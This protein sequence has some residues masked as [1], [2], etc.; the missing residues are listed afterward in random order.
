MGSGVIPTGSYFGE[1][2]RWGS[3]LFL[4]LIWPPE[5]QQISRIPPNL[6]S[7]LKWLQVA[8]VLAASKGLCLWTDIVW[9]DLHYGGAQKA[10]PSCAYNTP[11]I[12]RYLPDLDSDFFFYLFLGFESYLEII[13]RPVASFSQ[14]MSP[15]RMAAQSRPKITSP[16]HVFW[17]TP[18]LKPS[19]LIGTLIGV[20]LIC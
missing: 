2:A 7:G 13:L 19:R 16:R 8:H 10:G 18:I 6:L 17:T 3:R 1:V 11:S 20:R 5:A 12:S 9:K 15:W 14:N 4:K